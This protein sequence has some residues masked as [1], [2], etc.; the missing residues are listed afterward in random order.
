[1]NG[2]WYLH[3]LVLGAISGIVVGLIIVLILSAWSNGISNNEIHTKTIVVKNI[4]CGDKVFG[5]NVS[6]LIDTDGNRFFVNSYEECG[7]FKPG[8]TLKINYTHTHQFLTFGSYFDFESI[9]TGK[10]VE[11]GSH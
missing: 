6:K 4:M 10:V 9:V 1:M 2:K 7:T 11:D 5:T 8:D 3:P